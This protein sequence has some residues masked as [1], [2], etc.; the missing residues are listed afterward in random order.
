[1]LRLSRHA[2]GA[3]RALT[4]GCSSQSPIK[5]VS[6][7]GHFNTFGEWVARSTSVTAA[8]PVA[9]HHAGGH[10]IRA[11][12]RQ[13]GAPFA[14]YYV[15]L[16]ETLT[17]LL[18][19]L[20]HYEY[21]GKGDIGALLKWTGFGKGDDVNSAMAKSVTYGPFTVSARLMTN[22]VIAKSFVALFAPLKVPFCI[23]TLPYLKRAIAQVAP[24]AFAVA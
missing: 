6:V 7:P 8:A 9:A 13:Y 11:L 24:R 4:R 16:T 1:M 20:L 21:L 15:A 2:V 17:C 10:G 14:V 18:T 12:I 23:A 22:F 3:P 19:Y 5:Q